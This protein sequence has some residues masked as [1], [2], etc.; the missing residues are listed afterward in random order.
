MTRTA[1]TDRG[2]SRRAP[3]VSD[4]HRLAVRKLARNGN[5]LTVSLPP[6]FVSAMYVLPGDDLELVYDHEWQGVFIRALRPRTFRPA[7]RPRE[8]DLLD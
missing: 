5:S 6:E 8:A 7:T 2:P 3:R 1:R 4:D